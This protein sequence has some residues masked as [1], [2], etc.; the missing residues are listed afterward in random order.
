MSL[1][2]K[3][4]HELDQ[5]NALKQIKDVLVNII[6]GYMRNDYKQAETVLPVIKE[7]VL[8]TI[9]NVWKLGQKT[10]YAAKE[11]D[12]IFEYKKNNSV[13]EI[14]RS[15]ERYNFSSPVIIKQA[16][17]QVRIKKN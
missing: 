2:L 3:I 1:K 16:D 17:K 6:L 10:F 15:Q 14:S 13:N 12:P 8:D 5:I 11:E 7:L 9:D 4:K